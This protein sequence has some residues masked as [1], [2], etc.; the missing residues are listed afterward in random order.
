MGRTVR[1]VRY[2]VNAQLDELRHYIKALRKEDREH[3]E[4]LYAD[5]KGHISAISYANPLNPDN[6]MMWSA[7]IE[8]QKKIRQLKDDIDR[9]QAT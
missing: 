7:M 1:P 9:L 6:L 3:F 8:L 5:I 4:E 2:E